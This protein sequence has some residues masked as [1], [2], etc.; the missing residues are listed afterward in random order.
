MCLTSIYDVFLLPRHLLIF[1]Y[2]I[3]L[4]TSK[5][6]IFAGINCLLN[7]HLK[8]SDLFEYKYNILFH[9][10][11]CLMMYDVRLI[12]FYRSN[13]EIMKDRDTNWFICFFYLRNLKILRNLG[14]LWHRKTNDARYC[15]HT[16]LVLIWR[17][18]FPENV[19]TLHLKLNFTWSGSKHFKNSFTYIFYTFIPFIY[20]IILNIYIWLNKQNFYL[21]IWNLRSNI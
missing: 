18:V 13:I 5:Q 20:S 11:T 21:A 16:L 8:R 17:P 6:K 2:N 12:I 3:I 4:H 9:I 7:C 19:I 14:I 15:F 10:F 1:I